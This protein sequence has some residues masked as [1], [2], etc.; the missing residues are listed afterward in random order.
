MKNT[1]PVNDYLKKEG[2]K[3]FLY[4]YERR[5]CDI[6][7]VKNKKIVARNYYPLEQFK[8]MYEKNIMKNRSRLKSKF[9][10]LV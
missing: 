3:K 9:Y 7:D 10:H 2:R 4:I 1:D 5:G 6:I 8:K